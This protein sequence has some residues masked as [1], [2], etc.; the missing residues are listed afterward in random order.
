M[1]SP[2]P[3]PDIIVIGAGIVGVS[4]ALHLLMRG[5]KVLLID[6]K[7]AGQ[8][9]SFGN[10]GIIEA[11]TVMPF[12]FPPLRNILEIVR[13]K[14]AAARVD[15]ASLLQTL[16]WVFQFWM[17]SGVKARR[18]NG[19]FLRPLV[20]GAVAEHQHLMH[21][22][23]AEKYLRTM[24]RA[25]IYRHKVSFLNDAFERDVA[26]EMG[27]PFDILNPEAFA[28]YE[29][30]LGRNYYKAVRWTSSARVTDPGAVVTAYAAR[31][32]RE[33]GAFLQKEVKNIRP[34]E[35]GW[36]VETQT[37][38][39]SASRV[40]LCTGPWGAE[41]LKPLGLRLPLN[42]KR[43]YHQHFK[44]REGAALS[45][46]IIDGDIGYGMAQMEKG[47]RLTTGAEFAP[48][49][50]APNPVQI[51]RSLPYARELFPLGEA[52][53]Q[54]PWMGSRPCFADSLPVIGPAPR[55]D[56][57]WLNLGHGHVGLTAGPASGRLIAEMMTGEKT[58]C[59]PAPYSAAR[60]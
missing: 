59:N 47:I 16:P 58:F 48:L 33:G 57:L 52:V 53:E 40:V 6:R 15:Y 43:G 29:P 28:D 34:H 18:G 50:A 56:G 31:F 5:Q 22:T 39:F 38:S 26:Q 11:S 51:R 12:S 20:A 2:L 23:D 9:T 4:T 42:F 27:V 10:L 13:D 36:K 14:N 49:R 17:K 24:G 41:M 37:E 7:E 25:R 1:A 19:R 45:H 55:Q 21:G 35:N 30:Y 54:T 3:Q 46:A 8:E 60:F 44:V 32:L